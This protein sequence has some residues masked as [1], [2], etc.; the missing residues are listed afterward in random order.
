MQ[1]TFAN[2]TVEYDAVIKYADRMPDAKRSPGNVADIL[3]ATGNIS[4]ENYRNKQ[5]VKEL[6][7]ISDGFL[8][9]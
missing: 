4:K 9:G 1:R 7:S 5:V 2:Q 8:V 6:R 3:N